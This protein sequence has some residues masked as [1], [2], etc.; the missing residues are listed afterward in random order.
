MWTRE[1]S[2]GRMG[3]N[4]KFKYFTIRH[5]IPA[6]VKRATVRFWS[7]SRITLT[8][9]AD[10]ENNT[11]ITFSHSIPSPSLHTEILVTDENNMDLSPHLTQGVV[12][13]VCDGSFLPDSKTG[14]AAWVIETTDKSIQLTGATGTTGPLDCQTACRSELFGILYSILHLK[15]LC[16]NLVL[17][18]TSF[19]IHCDGL[20]AIQ[21]IENTINL[22]NCTKNILTSSTQYTNYCTHF[23]SKLNSITSKVIK[24]LA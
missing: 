9:W 4:S 23:P 12:N 14:A 18:T 16:S 21:S 15:N 17:Q 22:H 10:S 3:P 2:R 20:S 7:P 19:H 11:T 24:T 13:I 5:R 8:G 1:T 6:S